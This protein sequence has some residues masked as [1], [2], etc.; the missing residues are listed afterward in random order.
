[1]YPSHLFTFS[2]DDMIQNATMQFDRWCRLPLADR[3]SIRGIQRC[4]D[5]NTLCGQIIVMC[6]LIIIILGPIAGSVLRSQADVDQYVPATCSGKQAIFNRKRVGTRE[7]ETAEV[8]LIDPAGTDVSRTV[9]LRYPNHSPMLLLWNEADV[10]IWHYSVMSDNFTC[11]VDNQALRGGSVRINGVIDPILVGRWGWELMV[12]IVALAASTIPVM[13]VLAV[14]T[15]RRAQTST[16]TLLQE[17]PDLKEIVDMAKHYGSIILTDDAYNT[18]WIVTDQQQLNGVMG[19][20]PP[21]APIDHMNPA[22]PPPYND[23]AGSYLRWLRLNKHRRDRFIWARQ[24][25]A[26]QSENWSMIA[27][28]MLIAITMVIMSLYVIINVERLKT[29]ESKQ[30]L[31]GITNLIKNGACIRATVRILSDNGSDNGS[32]VLLY[33]STVCHLIVMRIDDVDKW[34]ASLNQSSF[35]CYVQSGDTGMKEGYTER[36]VPDYAGWIVMLVAGLIIGAVAF[37]AMLVS[38]L[39]MLEL[40]RFYHQVSADRQLEFWNIDYPETGSVTIYV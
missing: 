2:Q 35:K 1:M 31:G 20:P 8:L 25:L 17:K 5:Q 21:Y 33:P 32:V 23:R 22:S 40:R 24:K 30:C 7:S 13:I 29:Y 9:I 6:A 37:I 14:L 4:R 16:Q 18:Y 34:L 39:D 28:G 38:F 10:K 26:V 19:A 36:E 3:E 15:E 12:G 27:F 11:Y